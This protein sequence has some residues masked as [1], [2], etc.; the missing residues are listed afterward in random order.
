MLA[1]P[2]VEPLVLPAGIAGHF[3][4]VLF[5]M[6]G[7]LV[8]SG[9]YWKQAERE[10]FATVGIDITDEMALISAAMSTADVTQ[11]WYQHQPWQGRPLAELETA[12]VERV[13]ALVAERAEPLEGVHETLCALRGAGLK[14]AL[15]S[16]APLALCHQTIGKIGIAPYFDAVFSVDH[17]E[18]GKPAPDIYLHAAQSLGVEPERCLVFEDSVAGVHAGVE[19]GMTVIAVPSEGQVFHEAPRLP[20]LFLASLTEF[21]R[22]YFPDAVR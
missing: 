16:N 22:R 20:H 5:D 17:V 19:A 13:M 21:C 2:Q 3:D 12:V 11:H 15:A 6:D 14:T 4:A 10:A 7:T 18:R 9:P 1:W 8:D